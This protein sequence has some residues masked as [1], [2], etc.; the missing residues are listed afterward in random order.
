MAFGD[1]SAGP[2]HVLPTSG[3][4]RYTGGLSV[5]KFMKTV[6]W[7]RASRDAS[8]ALAVATARISRLEGM[9]GHARSADIRLARFFPG[10]R[11]EL[12][13]QT[14]AH[15]R[16]LAAG[17][18]GWR[19]IPTA[20]AHCAASSL[21]RAS[22]RFIADAL[23]VGALWRAGDAHGAAAGHR[24]PF[25]RTEAAR[26]RDRAHRAACCASAWHCSVCGSASTWR[27]GPLGPEPGR[28]SPRPSCSG[29][30]RAC[31]AEAG[32]S[33]CSPAVP[34]RS[35]APRPP[36]RSPRSCRATRSPRATALHGVAVSTLAM[37]AMT[38]RCSRPR[39]RPVASGIFIGGTIHDVA[40]VVGAGFSISNEAGDLA[41]L[42]KL[43]RVPCW[44]RSCC[45][46]SS[47]RCGR[48]V[49]RRADRIG[50]PAFVVA[51]VAIVL[52]DSTGL[53]PMPVRDAA[54]VVSQ[55]LLV[56]AIAA[57]G[58]K[59]SLKAMVDLGPQH[60]LLVVGETLFLL[61]AALGVDLLVG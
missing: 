59:T 10:E 36:W 28:S 43:F 54:S 48:R 51:F 45:S 2:N 19:W 17:G 23:P 18:V 8:R 42:V 25:P 39:A 26:R 46:P 9:E 37:V 27:P 20:A 60:I 56:V 3:A 47:C 7:Q 6:T 53:V 21:C 52:L 29:C 50:L 22:C 1:K 13:R 57:L 34:S 16:R 31:S 14:T 55:W 32:A 24:L 40:Q 58:V 35:A 11:F 30:S 38:I 33:R 12:R 15:E 49:P 41:T 4:A 5:H 61:L 44:P